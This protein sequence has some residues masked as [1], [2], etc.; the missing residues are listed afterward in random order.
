MVLA[1]GGGYQAYFKQDR[2]GAVRNP[3]EIDVMAEVARFCR[4]R[5]AYCHRSVAVPQIALLYSTAGIIGNH[6]DYILWDR[7][8]QDKYRPEAKPK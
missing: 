2:D 8:K 5:Q 3:A 4:K 1:L 6:R 7:Q